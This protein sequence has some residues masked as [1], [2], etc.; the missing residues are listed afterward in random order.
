MLSLIVPRP[1]TITSE[2]FDILIE[3]SVEES[4]MLWDGGVSVR[5]AIQFNGM[6][7]FNMIIIIMW[8]MH[9]LPTYGIIIKLVTKRYR[10]CPCCGVNTMCR[11]ACAFH[12]N[13]YCSQ[14]KR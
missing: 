2:Q 3:P 9:D 4:K 8:T 13:I 12:K 5:D 1:T 6:G 11:R 10:G 14:H 7:Q